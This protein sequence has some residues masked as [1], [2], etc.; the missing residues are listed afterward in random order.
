MLADEMPPA[1]LSARQKRLWRET[2]A[3]APRSVLRRIDSQLVAAYVVHVDVLIEATKAQNKSQLTDA[4]GKPSPYLRLLRQHSEVMIRLS[5]EMGFTPV[6]RARL[7][8]PQ[9]P[10]PA[11]PANPHAQFDVILPDGRRIPYDECAKRG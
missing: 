3:A 1:W 4:E 9:A 6:A 11:E 10:P 2:I 7:G 5:A 8:A